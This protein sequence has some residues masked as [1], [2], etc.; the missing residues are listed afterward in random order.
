MKKILKRFLM[1]LMTA[2]LFIPLFLSAA[3]LGQTTAADDSAV[4]SADSREEVVYANLATSGAAKDVFVVSILHNAASGTVA[5]YGV[6]GS[7]KN[8]TDTS[9]IAL[10]EDRVMLSVPKGDFYYQGTLKNP[11]LPWDVAISYSLDGKELP[12]EQLAGKNGHVAIKINTAQNSAADPVFFSNYMLQISV[13]LDTAK[14]SAISAPGGTVANAGSSKSINFA[15]MPGKEGS[16]TL[17]TDAVDFSMAGIQI[18]ALPL[19]MKIDPPDMSAM[20][21]DLS[22][23][24][25]AVSDLNDGLGKLESGSNDL[26]NGA[27]QLADGSA[28]FES[29]LTKLSKNAGKLTAGSAQINDALTAMAS[30]LAGGDEA[31]GADLSGLQKLPDGLN[32]LA[33][34]LDGISTGLSDLKAGF[35]ASYGA[36]K[37]AIL[38]IP[39]TQIPQEDWG[40]LYQDNPDK[41]VLIDTLAAYYASAVKTKATYDN[42]RPFFDA[43]E[44][45][46]DKLGASV[47][48]IS[49]S[50]RDISAQVTS[51]L[52]NSDAFSQLG[53]LSAGL[54]QLSAQYGDFQKG[55]A[56][57]AYGMSQLD[58]NYGALGS[59]INGL[60]DGAAKLADGLGLTSDGMS[61]LNANVKDLPQKTDDEIQKLMNDY[62][63]SGLKPP[64]FASPKNINTLSV[65]FVLKTDK[66]EKPAVPT[67][68]AAPEQ[69]ETIWTRIADLFN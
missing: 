52:G 31:G 53:Q 46:L 44:G 54:Q 37:S 12:A 51:A 21:Q 35:A 67:A 2:A 17:E 43:A 29:G 13:T 61:E 62:D 39:A 4:G 50:L 34:G 7:A 25:D 64:S 65:Q 47:G 32:Q 66:I 30:A 5:D 8:L 6:Y 11:I 55:L 10:A 9:A 26:K 27:N 33:A 69:K 18:S 60:A 56:S 16:L 63:K 1:G 19:S 22:K 40:R 58:S 28:S 59:G 57:F 24:T 15:V 42:V 45:A 38:E 49:G 48:Q 20:K 41:K 36:L 68:T 14:C 3:A 23:L